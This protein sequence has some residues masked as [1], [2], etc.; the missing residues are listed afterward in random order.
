RGRPSRPEPSGTDKKVTPGLD[1]TGMPMR[2]L[3]EGCRKRFGDPARDGSEADRGA[4]RFRPGWLL[5][6]M[7]FL[8]RDKLRIV[9]RDQD[10]LREHGQVVWGHLVQANTVLFNPRNRQ[11]LPANVLYS[12]DPY[13]DEQL[14]LL[15]ELAHGIFDL[16]G[17]SPRDKEMRHFAEAI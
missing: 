12:P 17:R 11:A 9:L 4:F 13:F 7:L 8:T 15:G 14:P 3:I 6:T 1:E 10:L 16:K 5:R 2:E